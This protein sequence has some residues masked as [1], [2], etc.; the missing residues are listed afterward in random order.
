MALKALWQAIVIAYLST[1]LD[2]EVTEITP[3]EDRC[4]F[5]PLLASAIASEDTHVIKLVYT[6]FCEYST[7]KEPL[8]YAVA[9]RAVL[10]E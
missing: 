9:Q 1:G 2:Y 5:A 8:Y 4:D 3:S 10:A 6:C 7:F